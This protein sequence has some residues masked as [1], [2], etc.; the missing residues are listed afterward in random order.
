MTDTSSNT[1]PSN[2]D[3]FDAKTT[4][5]ADRRRDVGNVAQLQPDRGQSVL[6]LRR[7]VG[8]GDRRELLV[9]LVRPRI[10]YS[11]RR[12]GRERPLRR[13]DLG[14]ARA[15]SA[16]TIASIPLAPG[17]VLNGNVKVGDQIL[18]TQGTNKQTF[19]AATAA[20]TYGATSIAV[21]PR[22]VVTSPFTSGAVVTN[23]SAQTLARL[24]L[25]TDNVTAFQTAH[26]LSRGRLELFPLSNNGAI[27]NVSGAAELTHMNSGTYTRTF[28]VGVY[29]PVPGGS[30]QNA[31]QGLSSTFGLT[32]HMTSERPRPRWLRKKVL[33]SLMVVGGLSCFTISA[34]PSRLLSA[35]T[36]NNARLDLV[37][38]AHVQQP[39]EHG[40][41]LLHERGP[42]EPRETS[43]PPA[44]RC[45][46]T[47]R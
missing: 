41:A 42:R 39:G 31:I 26:H 5:S 9:L 47:R 32:W 33:L 44:T 45:S 29:L 14:H 16:A 35:E 22:S 13:A 36:Q 12:R 34:A 10:D 30:N 7:H 2:T 4:S 25:A 1:T 11:T 28:Y 6:R 43:T 20:Q 40:L 37:R 24:E 23:T 3:C 19:T 8:P 38:H 27:D 46:R 18:V 15:A 17:T 21:T